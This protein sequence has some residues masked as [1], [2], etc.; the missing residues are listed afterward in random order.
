MQALRLHT[1]KTSAQPLGRL[2]QVVTPL[3]PATHSASLLAETAMAMATQTPRC[4]KPWCFNTAKPQ[5]NHLLGDMPLYA[6]LNNADDSLVRIEN[7]PPG[8]LPENAV[9][10]GPEHETRWVPVDYEGEPAHD[11]ATHYLRRLDPVLE[12]GKWRYKYA[13]TEKEAPIEVPLWAF[14]AVLTTMGL[15]GNV[16]TLIATLDEPARTVASVQW[17]YANFIRRDHPVIVQLAQALN[18]TEQDV[19]NIFKQAS[20]LS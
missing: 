6:L 13:V 1:C 3:L 5:P 12:D 2:T 15:A 17:E 9:N 7:Q 11:A 16:T 8:W 20:L 14:R 10:F 4:W 19:A 18:L